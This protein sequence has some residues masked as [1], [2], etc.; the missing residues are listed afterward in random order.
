VTIFFLSSFE[1]RG[2]E[3]TTC[4]LPIL[5]VSFFLVICVHSFVREVDSGVLRVDG[6]WAS[7][8]PEAIFFRSIGSCAFFCLAPIFLE[9][10]GEDILFVGFAMRCK[11][12]SSSATDEMVPKQNVDP[13]R[14]TIL[15]R[16]V[17]A[18]ELA[19]IDDTPPTW[20]ASYQ[21]FG[22]NRTPGVTPQGAVRSR[23]VLST[24]AQ[25]FMPVAR[26]TGDNGLQVRAALKCVTPYVLA[27]VLYV[28]GYKGVLWCGECRELGWMA[29]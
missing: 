20:H 25:R 4:S 24:V 6:P 28:V 29:E 11:V 13:G 22:S 3:R 8:L 12:P 15:C 1:G 18:I 9:I 17:T 16:K 27:R 26:E 5:F 14:K 19:W 7:G 21:C 23:T 2:T 10:S